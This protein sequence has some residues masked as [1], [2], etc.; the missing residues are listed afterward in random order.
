M[1]VPDLKKKKK[2]LLPQ[3]TRLNSRPIDG[4]HSNGL[5]LSIVKVL[6]E[7]RKGTVW[8]ES[9]KNENGSEFVAGIPVSE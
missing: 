3:F 6:V 7:T 4:D 5:G 8:I 1:I 9:R 2:N